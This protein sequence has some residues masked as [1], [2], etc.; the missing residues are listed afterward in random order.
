[1]D[2]AAGLLARARE[3]WRANDLD[4]AEPLL[5][6]AIVH[7]PKSGQA[8]ELLGKLLYRQARHEEAAAVYRAWL[9]AVPTDPVA[10]HLV[11]ATGG[12]NPPGRACDGYLESVFGRAAPEFDAMLASLGYRAPQLVFE[13]AM[14]VLDP[15]SVALDVLDLGCG[16]GLCGE[17]FR[18]LARWLV[19]V[20]LSADMLQ[21]AHSRGCYDELIR[22]EIGAYVNRCTAR[23]DVI[24]A[25]DVFCYFGDLTAVFGAV[26]ALLR[27]SGLFVF[28]VEEL[29]I[30]AAPR[31][32][33]SAVPLPRP[34]AG[35]SPSLLEHGRYAHSAQYLESIL[36]PQGLTPAAMKPGILRFERGAPVRGLLAAAK[37]DGKSPG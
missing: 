3:S 21:Q 30:S 31:D 19:G 24:T 32:D 37:R 20:D 22:E 34:S 2:E 17:W 18:P 16:T 25:A 1:M 11:A 23:F 7:D 6:R 12:A 27:P 9:Q 29:P 8:H 13:R 14:E 33:D 26:A 36:G 4:S 28:S 15:A 35:G 5:R 10:A